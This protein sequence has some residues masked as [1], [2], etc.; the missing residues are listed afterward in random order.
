MSWPLMIL[1]QLV[2]AATASK[3][4]LKSAS[5]S[6]EKGSNGLKWT[7][8]SQLKWFLTEHT[9]QFFN[10]TA[11]VHAMLMNITC[12]P[13]WT[14]CLGRGTQIGAWLG[15]TGQGVDPTLL[16][17]L[18]LMWLLSSWRGWGARGASIMGK[19][20][21]F[22]IC[23]LGSSCLVLCPGLLRL[24]QRSCILSTTIGTKTEAYHYNLPFNSFFSSCKFFYYLV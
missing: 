8:N 5:G 17:L 16:L 3:C 24:H 23:L 14:S 2:V 15:L 21:M 18:G 1:A 13:L 19:A 10:S 9:S 22:A 7:E 4:Y 20:A 6:G 11:K 12:Q